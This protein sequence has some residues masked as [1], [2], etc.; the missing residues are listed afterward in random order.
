MTCLTSFK[1]GVSHLDEKSVFKIIDLIGLEPGIT[2]SYLYYGLI[3]R[4]S[5]D[6]EFKLFIQLHD[7]LSIIYNKRE[8][9]KNLK[10]EYNLYYQV[11]VKF[12]D[13][14]EEISKNTSF[15]IAA[16]SKNFIEYIDAFYNFQN[17]YFDE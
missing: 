9:L 15:E 8:L 17:G 7:S 5:D 14:E 3:K 1:I 10:Q 6:P 16:E 13:I 11:D 4:D 2:D 12:S